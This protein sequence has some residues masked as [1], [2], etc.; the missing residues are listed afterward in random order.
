MVGSRNGHLKLEFVVSLYLQF[1]RTKGDFSLLQCSH[2]SPPRGRNIDISCLI[3]ISFKAFVHTVMAVEVQERPQFTS[4]LRKT[5][6]W[7]DT[8]ENDFWKIFK[9]LLQSQ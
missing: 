6:R 7:G 2:D 5:V 9:A 1:Q 8:A 3:L 4:M